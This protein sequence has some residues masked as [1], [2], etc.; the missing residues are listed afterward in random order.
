MKLS[1]SVTFPL[2]TLVTAGIL[3][4]GSNRS[5]VEA[6]TRSEIIGASLHRFP[7]PE[8]V[9]DDSLIAR[10]RNRNDFTQQQ[11]VFEVHPADPNTHYSARQ[12]EFPDGRVLYD[13]V[14]CV[15][16]QQQELSL[17]RSSS[18]L[19]IPGFSRI[20]YTA[21]E[22]MGVNIPAISQAICTDIRDRAS[23][24]VAIPPSA[25]FKIV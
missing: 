2:A 12:R 8:A 18:K 10:V 13:F 7:S 5:T 15:Y 11:F 22:Y 24:R 23:Q 6:S 4:V 14:E 16:T 21:I 1:R 17:V 9:E 19:V 20:P 25:P 3:T